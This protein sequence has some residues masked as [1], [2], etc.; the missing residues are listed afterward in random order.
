MRKRLEMKLEHLTPGERRTLLPV[1]EEYLDLFCNEKTGVLPS[2]TK[3]CHEIRI[4][5]ALPIKKNPCRVPYSLRE[6]MKR[7]LDEMLAKGVITP[8]SPWPAPVIL[9]PKKSPDRTPKYTF[10]TDFRGLNSV[11]TTPVY[12]I[13]D[14]KSNLSV[15]A[16]SRYFTL[17]DIENAYWNIPIRD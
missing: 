2:T 4:G 15:M 13:P 7:Q 9:V 14:I 6:E 8:C 1:M 16:G 3:G 10:C 5:D 11:T 17:L 12:L